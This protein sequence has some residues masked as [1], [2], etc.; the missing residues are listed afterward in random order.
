MK[1]QTILIITQRIEEAENICDNI[2]LMFDGR[3]KDY[4]SPAILKSRHGIGYQLKI[5]LL[6]IDSKEQI[7]NYVRRSFPFCE[8]VPLDMLGISNKNIITYDFDEMENY[9]SM[10][11]DKTTSKIAYVFTEIG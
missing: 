3:L 6:N 11:Q 7:E 10:S 9:S 8:K 5:Q 1:D 2:A 4:G